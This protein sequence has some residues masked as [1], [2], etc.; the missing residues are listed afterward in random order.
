MANGLF[1][2]QDENSLY[3]SRSDPEED[4]GTTSPHPFQLEEKIWPTV[5][6]YFHAMK[7]TDDRYQ[8]EIRNANTPK[9]AKKLGRSRRVKIRKD[10]KQVKATY[11]TRAV[12]TKCC[13]HPHI[14]IKLLDTD[15][16]R[17]VENSQ[18]DYYWGCGRDRLGINMY[19]Q[20]LMNIRD[21]FREAIKP[22]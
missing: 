16:K 3:F 5:E 22:V 6:H 20:L 10:W 9:H 19:G 8:E 18:Y 15:D 7:F 4:F 13:A 12:Y 2:E 17:L 11:M 14:Q 1:P 21:K